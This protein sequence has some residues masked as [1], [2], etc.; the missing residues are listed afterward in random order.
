MAVLPAAAQEEKGPSAASPWPG[1]TWTPGEAGYGVKLEKQS[2]V[3]MSDGTVLRVD[4]A[5][6]TDLATGGRAKGPF[7]VL[8]TQ[9][10]YL[11]TEPTAG[12]YFVRRGYIFV[13]AYIRGTTT[14][15]GEFGF[16]DDREAKDGAE[17][18]RWAAEQLENSNGV[19]GLNGGSYAGI[20]QFLTVAELGPSSPVK[21]MAPYCMGAELYRE[22]YFAGG[23]PSQTLN[24]QRVIG[25]AMG[26]KTAQTGVAFLDDVTAGGPRAYDGTYWRLRTVGNLAQKV[27]DTE[28]PI[29]LWS[30]EG[31]IYAQSSLELYTYLQNAGQKRPVFGQMARDQAASGR[32]QIVM[33]QGGHCENSDERITLEWYDTWLKG[34]KTGMADTRAPIHV[35]EMISN[36]WFNTGTYPPVATYTRYYLSAGRTLS[37]EPPGNESR[38]GIVWAQPGAGSVLQFDSESFPDGATLAGPISASV[39]ASSNTKNLELIATV[40]VVDRDG[41]ATKISSGT[42]LGS[43][44]ENDPDR[45]WSDANGIPVR[46][47][48]K[49]DAE[50]PVVP[51]AVDK[52]DFAVSARFSSIPPGS[53]LRL[54]LTTQTPADKCGPALGLDPCFPTAPQAASLAGNTTTLHYGPQTASSLNLPLA[55]AKCWVSGDNPGIPFWKNDPEVA[56]DGPCQ[57]RPQ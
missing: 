47:Y 9:T 52:Y 51:G 35:H 34:A 21:A 14:S 13:T 3:R 19:V 28:V 31:D 44:A 7:P 12:D 16:F 8:L 32:Y 46:P 6:P 57:V 17:L 22:P 36:R 40:Q 24:F 42:L 11:N 10:P 53:K 37:K 27:A 48:G 18:V 54:V 33:G 1:G 5:Y 26:G 41:M 2:S 15:G 55:P 38:D 56:G 43:L 45:S 23:I 4:I 20:N 50:K 29:L 25:N 39:Y 49:Y 30:N